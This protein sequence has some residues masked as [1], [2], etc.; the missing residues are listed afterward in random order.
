MP[1]CF[2]SGCAAAVSQIPARNDVVAS[3]LSAEV[4]VSAHDGALFAVTAAASG[5]T[6]SFAASKLA[7]SASWQVGLQAG[8]FSWSYPIG[9]PKV[10]GPEPTVDLQYSSADVDGRAGS[11]NN[12]PSWV[13]E[14]FD[15]PT[16]YIER[17]YRTCKDDGGQL[18]YTDLCWVSQNA[19]SSFDP[20]S[21]PLVRDDATGTWRAQ[22]D[23]GWR[24]EQ[25]TGAVNGD[26][27]GEYWKLTSPEGTAYFF[28]LNRLPVGPRGAET[29]FDADRSRLRR[30]RRGALLRVQSQQLVVPTGYRWYLDYVVDRHGDAMSYW[31]V[32]ESSGYGRR[33]TSEILGTVTPYVRAAYLSRIDYGQRDGAVYSGLP[34]ARVLFTVADRCNTTGSACDPANS[35][36]W[37]DW[38][39]V[40]W[41]QQ[42][43]TICYL[44]WSPT[45][46]TT[47]RLATVTTQVR[48]G[49]ALANVDS[50]T[51]RQSYPDPYPAA[52]PW[53]AENDASRSLWLNGITRRGLSG[54]TVALPE[55]T[56]TGVSLKNRH[57][58]DSTSPSMYK[59]RVSRINNET[60]GTVQVTYSDSS[61]DGLPY[62]FPDQAT[63]RCFRHGT[64]AAGGADVFFKYVV[65]AVA[66][67]DNVG[68]NPTKTTN[69]EYVGGAAWHFDES[70]ATAPGER[71]WNQW[72][73]FQNVRVRTG[74]SGAQ[75]MTEYVYLRGSKVIR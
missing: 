42:C 50:W 32:K 27:N 25:L 70:D 47:K 20:M 24:A 49:A 46:W 43:G 23:N 28:G 68:G 26:N 17:S 75:T 53:G 18:K 64:R 14:G 2:L 21:G 9:L 67:L 33:G 39:D 51:L 35:G 69:Y 58:G 10:P 4:A 30:R 16:P 45:F 11:S 13:G 8:D 6:G 44:Q 61:C 12:Q 55:V 63:G 19:M 54:G 62:V 15:L 65:T 73:G 5:S 7:P 48:S 3:R 36:N 66:E 71:T 52:E 1:E 40:P 34:A 38:P 60:G 74:A 29:E 72:R 22:N 59:W 41:D 57:N 37:R 31:Y 56:F